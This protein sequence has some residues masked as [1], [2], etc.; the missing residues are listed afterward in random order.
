MYFTA[1]ST[2]YRE[3]IYEVLATDTVHL[4]FRGISS[5]DDNIFCN[6][7]IYLESKC[8]QYLDVYKD[9]YE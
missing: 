3:Y 4:G 2:E 7:K 5:R 9:K 1:V 6:M 8:K